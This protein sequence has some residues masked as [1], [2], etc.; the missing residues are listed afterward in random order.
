MIVY[1]AGNF[2][3][4]PERMW[5]S[6]SIDGVT[7]TPRFQISQP[8]GE[9]SNG[10]PAI[11][12]GLSAGDFRVVWQGDNGDR[13]GWNTFFRQTTDG[14]ATWSETVRLSDRGRGAPYKSNA[15]YQFPYGDYLSLSV[16]GDGVNHVIWG[17]GA[18][19]DGPGGSWYTRGGK[20]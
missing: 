16:D 20:L 2:A 7:W 15:G 6:T 4:E 3:R 12:A 19:Y 8:N 18:S 17:E 5:I 11:A 13:E 10:F 9:A 1:H 14:G